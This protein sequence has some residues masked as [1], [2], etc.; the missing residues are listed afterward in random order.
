MQ[1]EQI[2][3]AFGGLRTW[4]EG[5]N[6]PGGGRKRPIYDICLQGASNYKLLPYCF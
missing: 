2:V 1:I 4:P 3:S 6:R 5:W